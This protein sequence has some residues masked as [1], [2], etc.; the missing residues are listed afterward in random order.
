[1]AR[2]LSARCTITFG[3]NGRCRHASGLLA[4][5]AALAGCSS[6]VAS[7]PSDM[8]VAIPD[9][10]AAPDLREIP[11]P[12]G[13]QLI[14][15]RYLVEGYTTDGYIL[16]LDS[17]DSTAIAESDGG[18]H[19]FTPGDDSYTIQGR[20]MFVWFNSDPRSSGPGDLYVWSAAAEGHRIASKS[21]QLLG[22]A[23]DDGQFVFYSANTSDDS[24]ATDLMVPR[25]MG[26]AC[27]ASAPRPSWETVGRMRRSPAHPSS[28]AIVRR[29]ATRESLRGDSS[30]STRSRITS[31][32]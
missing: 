2:L 27:I 10:T 19:P 5:T 31:S 20:V 28:S 18:V 12:S 7:A 4:I 32:R 15:D 13:A 3:F 26:P 1:M 11:P 21:Q 6:S 24:S 9:L 22:R 8:A 17:P 25:A 30:R 16:G 23:S 14:G 29:P